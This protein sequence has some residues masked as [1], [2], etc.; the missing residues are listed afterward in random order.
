MAQ[1]V[2]EGKHGLKLFDW[3]I[4]EVGGMKPQTLD[5]VFGVFDYVF[6]DFF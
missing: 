3:A 2:D 1:V 6:A 5:A 4:G